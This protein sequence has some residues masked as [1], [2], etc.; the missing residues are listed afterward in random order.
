MLE[1]V[2]IAQL[3]GVFNRVLIDS[4]YQNYCR[5]LTD[6]S[7]A[8]TSMSVQSILVSEAA[9]TGIEQAAFSL[10]LL[11]TASHA[12]QKP[13]SAT[14]SDSMALR[15]A[16]VTAVA[17]TTQLSPPWKTMV[18]QVI[19][20]QWEH[21]YHMLIA[22][23]CKLDPRRRFVE[24]SSKMESDAQRMR[25][26]LISSLDSTQRKA[27]IDSWVQ[28]LKRE[29]CFGEPYALDTAQSQSPTDWWIAHT[30]SHKELREYIAF[31]ALTALGIVLTSSDPYNISMN[32]D[33]HLCANLCDPT[34]NGNPIHVESDSTETVRTAELS[35]DI[36]RSTE[37]AEKLAFIRRNCWSLHHVRREARSHINHRRRFHLLT[38]SDLL[39][40]GNY[41]PI[42]ST[43]EQQHH[44]QEQQHHQ[45]QQQQSQSQRG[46]SSQNNSDVPSDEAVVSAYASIEEFEFA[47]DTTTGV[48][49]SSSHVPDSHVFSNHST[50][51]I[52]LHPGGAPTQQLINQHTSN[53]LPVVPNSSNEHHNHSRD[54]N[55]ERYHSS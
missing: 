38:S 13:H 1:V 2:N 50:D 15:D 3:A 29:D 8:Q 19:A 48:S 53:T 16:L 55:E 9:M 7:A 52:T 49:S 25:D 31:P 30:A 6:S 26:R 41:P 54:N 47:H 35:S 12:S 11:L 42:I 43:S 40:E 45:Q 21:S 33:N 37:Q 34:C 36:L 32:T 17:S 44:H 46:N 28:M 18:T 5:T 14:F 24:L 4:M 39:Q 23:A 22:L 27:V 10:R 51:Y 20:S